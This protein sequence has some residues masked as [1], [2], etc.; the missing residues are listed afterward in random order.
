MF[1]ALVHDTIRTATPIIFAAC[2]GLLTQV[3][4]WLNIGLEGLILLA[5]FFAVVV[6]ALTGSLLLGTVA[7]VIVS[8]ALSGFMFLLIR[9]LRA[10]LFVVGIATNLFASGFTVL[11]ADVWFQSKGTV[12]FSSSPRLEPVG[13]NFLDRVG[14]S[15]FNN[16]NPFDYLAFGVLILLYF[17]VEKSIFG[18]K[19]KACGFDEESAF[20][21]GVSVDAVRLIGFLTG[22]IF[23]GLAGASLSL[24][25]GAFV[26]NMSGGRGW[27]ALVAV[28]MGKSKPVPVVVAALILGF[29]TELSVFLQVATQVSPK[30]LLS[31]PYFISFAIIALYPKDFLKKRVEKHHR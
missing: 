30:L 3:T 8:V 27:I 23:A 5:A 12:V 7:A 25:L 16:L 11:L 29:V 20:Y 13:L 4:G 21:A 26:A 17:V 18:L 14:L 6:S 31:L 10:N 9:Y 19:L 15:F 22:G 2:G 24:P 1:E 28:V